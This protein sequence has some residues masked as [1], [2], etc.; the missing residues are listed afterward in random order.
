MKTS[1]V[2][3]ADLLRIA[4]TF[5]VILL[6]M[7]ARHWTTTSVNTFE[8]QAMNI[9]EG[10]V[11]WCVP[12]FFMI[13]GMFLLRSEK[14]ITK[15]EI[16]TKYIVKLIA[17]LIFWGL[18]YGTYNL[19][20]GHVLLN[21]VLTMKR[22]LR[23]PVNLLF[24]PP[25]YHLWFIYAIIGMYAL[26]PLIR[27]FLS[28]AEKRDLEYLLLLFFVFG[29]VVP[30]LNHYFSIINSAYSINMSI[31]ELSGYAGYFIAGY[32]FSTFDVTECRKRWLYILSIL[33]LVITVVVTSLSSLSQKQPDGTLYGYLL[34]NTMVIA[35]AVFLFFK[36]CSISDAKGVGIIA[37]LSRCTFGVYLVHALI[38]E[39]LDLKGINA[40]SFNTIL[41]IPLLSILVFALSVIVVAGCKRIPYFNKYCI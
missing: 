3:Y 40:L 30:L 21:E 28:T 20:M 34:P 37:F 13:S 16:Y 18:L 7:S 17:A 1:R 36:H 39:L 41:S 4:A 19:I 33:S 10:I 27:L 24:G 9:F 2:L 23:I 25:F 38:I 31:P 6:H 15:K 8:W 26:T 29:M 14:T 5:A 35:F 11:R 12:V 22:I 32:Y